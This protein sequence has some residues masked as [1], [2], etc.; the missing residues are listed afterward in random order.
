VFCEVFF[1]LKIGFV[2]FWQ[3][4]IGTKAA[5]KMLVKLTAGPL[6]RV[7]PLLHAHGSL[8]RHLLRRLRATQE[9]ELFIIVTS[10][11]IKDLSYFSGQL[12]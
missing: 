8:E 6:P 2:I 1:Y 11:L 3:K 4:N 9:T 12:K 10:S 5:R 7:R